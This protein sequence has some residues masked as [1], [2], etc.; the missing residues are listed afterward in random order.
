MYR[1][2]LKMEVSLFSYVCPNVNSQHRSFILLIVA[3]TIK[4]KQKKVKEN[5]LPFKHAVQK[6]KCSIQTL[7][8]FE[9]K[10]ILGAATKKLH[11]TV[12][13]V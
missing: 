1:K 5:K 7:G 4:D 12:L 10:T 3:L 6:L 8:D 2:N 13:E 9:V 11:E